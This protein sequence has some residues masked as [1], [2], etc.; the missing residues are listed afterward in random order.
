MSKTIQSPAPVPDRNENAPLGRSGAV[1]RRSVR[2]IRTNATT[3]AVMSMAAIARPVATLAADKSAIAPQIKT[4]RLAG[5]V[6]LTAWSLP[7]SAGSVKRALAASRQ[8][9]AATVTNALRQCP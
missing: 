3:V 4:R 1:A 2:I 5:K 6:R 7:L 8:P 9:I